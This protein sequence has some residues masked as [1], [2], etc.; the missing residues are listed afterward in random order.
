[1]IERVE[2]R[3]T[4]WGNLSPALCDVATPHEEHEVQQ[5]LLQDGEKTTWIARG[6]GRSYGD[7]SINRGAGVVEHTGLWRIR[8]FDPASGIIDCQAGVS[9]A[10]IAAAAVPRG[11]FLPVTPGTQFVTIGG[12]IAADVHGKNHHVDGSLARH[13]VDFR[14]LTATGEM[15]TCGP[16]QNQ[17]VFWA[18]VGGMGLTG[19]ILSARIRL[20]PIETAF[21]VVDD[22]KTRDLDE[23]LSRLDET[24]ADYKYSIA[25]IDCLA[26]AGRLGRSVLMQAN[27]AEVDH[28]PAV[29]RTSPLS[30]PR[31][32]CQSLPFYLPSFTLNRFSVGALNRA[33]YAL[34]PVG[35][36][37]VDLARYFYPLDSLRHWNRMYGRRGFVQYQAVL[38]P[39]ASRRAMIQLLEHMRRS[40]IGSFFA[41]LKSSG[42]ASG[43]LLSFMRC[44]H[45]I[46]FD[47]PYRRHL[48]RLLH[49]L[50]QIVLSHGGRLYLAKDAMMRPETFAAMY[51]RLEAFRRIQRH[52]DPRG[53]LSSSQA[54]RLRIVEPA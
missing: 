17:D 12:A 21:V 14:L 25:W 43:G 33:F 23:T 30:M 28:L 3:L 52:L 46:A 11:R 39:E 53:I 31:V 32:R 36:R 2:K 1:M 13:V 26:A 35:R 8:S 50:D 48:P 6:L 10:Q 9:I 37:V 24:A 18:T 27:P 45:T 44:G 49:E 5:L 15:L 7:S 51:P 19:M 38:P 42:P 34:H 47:L 20:A 4:G 22:E 40:R 16:D 41:G 54:R 29:R